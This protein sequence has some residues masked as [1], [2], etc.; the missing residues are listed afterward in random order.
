[1][2]AHSSFVVFTQELQPSMLIL[3]TLA[4]CT[5]SL[6]AQT[7]QLEDTQSRSLRNW[8]PHVQYCFIRASYTFMHALKWSACAMLLVALTIAFMTE[9]AFS[10]CCKIVAGCMIMRVQWFSASSGYSKSFAHR[11]TNLCPTKTSPYA[12]HQG[13]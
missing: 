1:M 13:S 9:R 4:T 8:P 10:I 6:S 2:L 11:A 7:A 5:G 3:Q 12:V